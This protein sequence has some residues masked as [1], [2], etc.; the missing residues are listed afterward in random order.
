MAIKIERRMGNF[1]V[2]TQLGAGLDEEIASKKSDGTA[3]TIER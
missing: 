2:R 3:R 1:L